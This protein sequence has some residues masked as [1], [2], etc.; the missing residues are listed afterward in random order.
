MSGSLKAG[1]ILAAFVIVAMASLSSGAALASNRL[2]EVKIT[3]D[4]K[5]VLVSASQPMDPE[6]KIWMDGKSRLVIHIPDM[7][8]GEVEQLVRSKGHPG[9][10]IKVKKMGSAV[11]LLVDFDSGQA[12]KHKVNTMANCMILFLEPGT[13]AAALQPPVEEPRWK[14]SAAAGAHERPA[15]PPPQ[16]GD[17]FVES[18]EFVNGLIVVKVASKKDPTRSYRI[19]LGVDLDGLGFNSANVVRVKP[20]A[21]ATP[22]RKP[23]ATRPVRGAAAKPLNLTGFRRMHAAANHRAPIPRPARNS[24]V[25]EGDLSESPAT[26]HNHSSLLAHN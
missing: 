8:P 26:G 6:P 20:Q 16:K 1:A 2:T 22:V 5:R 9:F 18:A 7:S 4:S 3:P 11:R 25:H 13:V 24:R 19:D 23:S 21:N 15:G 14:K 17:L 12:P 10:E